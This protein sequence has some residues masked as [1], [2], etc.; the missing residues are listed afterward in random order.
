MDV[1]TIKC[2]IGVPQLLIFEILS[3][4]LTLIRPRPPPHLYYIYIIQI[5]IHTK[6]F[7][8]EYQLDKDSSISILKTKE[9]N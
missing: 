1:N 4:S 8:R 2:L 3:Y 6:S 7:H 5:L 9:W